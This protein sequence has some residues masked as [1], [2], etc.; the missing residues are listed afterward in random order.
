MRGG[1]ADP[2]GAGGAQG[3]H[4]QAVGQQLVVGRGQGVEDEAPARRVLAE[5]VPEEGDLRRLVDRDPHRDAVGE[6]PRDHRGVLGE[7]LG[8][9]PYQPAAPLLQGERGVPVE[10]GGHRGDAAGAQLVDEPVVEVQPLAVDPPV[11]VG[12][13]PRPGDREPVGAD[14][15][16]GHQRHVLAVATV[17]VGG[18]VRT[19]AVLDPARFP[20]EGVPGG[21]PPAVRRHRPL[22]LEG[23]RGDTPQE[24]DGERGNGSRCRCRR[25][26]SHTGSLRSRGAQRRFGCAARY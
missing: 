11:P 9:V 14:A 24:A 22:D 16:S 26:R 8:G 19:R 25:R 17:V 5:A 3:L 13:D 7:P 10:E 21:R 18:H 2:A 20:G 12:Q 4:P 6:P 23:G 15:E 1:D